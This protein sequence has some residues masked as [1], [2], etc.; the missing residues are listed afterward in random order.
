MTSSSGTKLL[1]GSCVWSDPVYVYNSK[2][3]PLTL[4]TAPA[5][6]LEPDGSSNTKI[7][8]MNV[9]LIRKPTG[10]PRRAGIQYR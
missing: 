6:G 8:G 1:N 3:R 10:R 5:C 4:E 7:S 9:H 2:D